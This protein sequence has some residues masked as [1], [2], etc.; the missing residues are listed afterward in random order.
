M[1]N[2]LR[3]AGIVKNEDKDYEQNREM[4]K[5]LNKILGLTIESQSKILTFFTERMATKTEES[6][7]FDS[8][9]EG[10]LDL[11]DRGDYIQRVQLHTV[12]IEHPSGR[13][14]TH[15]HSFAVE[16]GFSWESAQTKV[17]QFSPLEKEEGFY[18]LL[19]DISTP[20]LILRGKLG[21]RNKDIQLYRVI[22][23]N[24]GENYVQISLQELLKDWVKMEEQEAHL[25]WID[26]FNKTESSCL[27]V[28]R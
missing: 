19:D 22:Y 16:A 24:C 10:T 6:K 13:N 5:F 7:D 27:H 4:E 1:L 20:A 18:K 11:G 26:F 3:T 21:G 15:L 23:P 14:E 28:L 17:T 2:V 25:R 8:Y 9:G 12:P